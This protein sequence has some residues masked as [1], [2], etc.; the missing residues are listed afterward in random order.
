VADA[1]LDPE[2]E[3]ALQSVAQGGRPIWELPVEEARAAEKELHRRLDP[4]ETPVDRSEQIVVPGPGGDIRCECFWPEATD[5]TLPLTI[6]L[7]GGGCVLL[8][9]EAYRPICSFLAHYGCSIVLVPAYRLAPESPFPAAWEDACA[10]FRWALENAEQLHADPE[11]IAVCGDSAGGNLATGIALAAKADDLPQPCAQIL[12]YP[13]LDLLE[14]WPS[15][16]EPAFAD[17]LREIEWLNGLYAGDDAADPR[18]S[19][20][21]ADDHSRLAPALIVAAGHDPLV[22]QGRA[23]AEKLARADVPVTHVLYGGAPHGFLS[24]AGVLSAARLALRQIA[25]SLHGFDRDP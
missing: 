9:P 25:F 16:R 22:E 23:Y 19:P 21:Y 7:H 8:D 24:M 4:A 13:N 12:I 3:A 5:E 18:A 17:T 15:Y 10:V 2:A 11:R 6:Y 1:Y 20:L 14:A